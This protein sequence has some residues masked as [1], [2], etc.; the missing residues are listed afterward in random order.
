MA[1]DDAID[2][3]KVHVKVEQEQIT[4]DSVKPESNRIPEWKA[5]VLRWALNGLQENLGR[6]NFFYFVPWVKFKPN[7]HTIF[8]VPKKDFVD[9][10][11]I[12]EEQYKTIFEKMDIVDNLDDIIT[13]PFEKDLTKFSAINEGIRKC[14]DYNELVKFV[15]KRINN[16][17]FYFTG[18]MIEH[19]KEMHDFLEYVGLRYTILEKKNY[20]IRTGSTVLAGFKVPDDV[21]RP[22]EVLQLKD[23][24][25]LT[26][27]AEY[28][29]DNGSEGV[30]TILKELEELNIFMFKTINSNKDNGD[31][32]LNQIY[33]KIIEH[34]PDLKYEV[35]K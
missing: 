7:L 4:T 5:Y 21:H 2:E 19:G 33:L 32:V 31:E 34:N 24:E 17:P 1:I 29:R 18:L 28:C 13:L 26:K 3:M 10:V 30:L 8:Q 22:T 23:I 11:T 20:L 9:L 35:I 16:I 12:K 15:K 25:K 27:Y 14:I 6:F